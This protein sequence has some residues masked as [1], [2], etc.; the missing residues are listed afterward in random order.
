MLLQQQLKEGHI[1]LQ[2]EAFKIRVIKGD[3]EKIDNTNA[4]KKKEK[5][6]GFIIIFILGE[7]S[8][9]TCCM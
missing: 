6:G 4:K 5:N 3:K 9:N 7:H 1:K 2:I 8:R